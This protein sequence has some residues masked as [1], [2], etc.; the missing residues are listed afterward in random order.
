MEHDTT[1]MAEWAILRR[2]TRKVDLSPLA[3][4]LFSMGS[5]EVRFPAA[6]CLIVLDVVVW[7]G[8]PQLQ[9]DISDGFGNRLVL[10]NNADHL[11]VG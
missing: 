2:M 3:K 5:L 7:K 1:G 10:D 8:L 6:L 4:S 9:E 11:F